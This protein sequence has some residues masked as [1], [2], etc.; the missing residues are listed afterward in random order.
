MSVENSPEDFI[1]EYYEIADV[2]VAED[3][4]SVSAAEVHGL[5]CGYLTAGADFTQERWMFAALEMMDVSS[6]KHESSRIAL[7]DLYEGVLSQMNNPDFTFRL[8]LP[9]DDL[10]LNERVTALGSWCQGFLVGFGLNGAHTDSSLTDDQLE[11]LRDLEQI[12]WVELDQDEDDE[13]NE[14]GLMELQEYVRMATLMFFS[15]SHPV[16]NS[17]DT[18]PEQPVLH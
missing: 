8:L 7:V 11:A 9:D 15:E 1:P 6:L 18:D 16:E 3:S 13:E 4:M 2:L 14:N 5:L 17:G 10:S 12:S